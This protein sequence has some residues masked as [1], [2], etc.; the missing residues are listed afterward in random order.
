MAAVEAPR[1]VAGVEEE[2]SEDEVMS[3]AWHDCSSFSAL[4]D[5]ATVDDRQARSIGIDDAKSKLRADRDEVGKLATFRTSSTVSLTL[6]P[7]C[8]F[9]VSLRRR[10]VLHL[11]SVSIQ[12]VQESLQCAA[13]HAQMTLKPW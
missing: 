3:P 4:Q 7:C 10:Q 11:L 8:F 5:S 2:K 13:F 1:D 6:C 12:K 9:N